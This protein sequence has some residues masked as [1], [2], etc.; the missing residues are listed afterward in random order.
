MTRRTTI[1][2]VLAVLT[3]GT[4][5]VVAFGAGNHATT[6]ATANQETTTATAGTTTAVPDA[7][8][9]FTNQTSNGTAVVVDR[10]V[11]PEGGFVAV[12]RSAEAVEETT[13]ATPTETLVPGGA[14]TQEYVADELVG[15]STYL[16]SGVHENVTVQLNQ[17]LGESQVLVA[18]PYEDTNDNQ[19]FDF[20]QADEPYLAFAPINDWARVTLESDGN[21]TTTGTETA[22]EGA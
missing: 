7:N 15:N 21:Q 14:A 19:Q 13:A 8:L 18:M 5:A 22:T 4:S 11:V 1:I 20:P 6:D 2:T 16:E 9:T 12:F 10:V 17:T 3:I